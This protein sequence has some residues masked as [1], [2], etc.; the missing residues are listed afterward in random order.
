VHSRLNRRALSLV[1]LAV[2]AALGLASLALSDVT[3][4]IL[5]T[6]TP[7]ARYYKVTQTTISDTIC[8]TGWTKTIRPPESYTKALKKE[9]LTSYGPTALAHTVMPFSALREV[10]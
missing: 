9:Q 10:S 7:A 5:P 6:H 4:L 8:V 1:A 3:A 2:A